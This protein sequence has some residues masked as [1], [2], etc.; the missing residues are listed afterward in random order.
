MEGAA[1]TS[2]T[3]AQAQ[4]RTRDYLPLIDRHRS[5]CLTATKLT[6]LVDKPVE[7]SVGKVRDVY[8]CG[9]FIV[10]VTTDRQSAFDRN[11]ASIPFKGQVLN[12]VSHWWFRQTKHIVDNHVLSCP[13]PNITVARTCQVFPVE[14]VMRGYITGSTN[15]SM[16]THYANGVR[17]YCGH[18]L[19][20]G[21]VKNQKLSA[22]LLTPTTKGEWRDDLISGEQ[23][24]ASGC[25]SRQDWD[26][27]A[28]K[29]HQ[30]FAFGQKVAESKGLILVDT[31]YEFGK[32]EYGNILLVD[33]IHTP[34]SSRYW[35]AESYEA[36]MAA[37]LDPENVDKEFL[38]LWFREQCDPY[39]DATLPAAP[40]EL[41]N[42]LSRRYIML[43]E[44]ITGLTF[45]FPAA[46]EATQVDEA[47]TR[48]IQ[49]FEPDRT[50]LS[51]NI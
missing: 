31:K 12:L 51:P 38:R 3:L 18:R 30:L 44:L 50:N 48:T 28:V 27:C 42:E 4:E 13:H 36:R 35:M 9:K 6:E 5:S 1:P 14:F 37:G 7:K 15:T 29:A 19:P 22:N 39:K 21:L 23:V 24:V 33:E 20:E 34:D 41:V 32:D 2:S 47:L 16:W 10:L 49:T 46:W 43:Y 40:T 17:D 26:E 8:H 45:E 11:I 25:M